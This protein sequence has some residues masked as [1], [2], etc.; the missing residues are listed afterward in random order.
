MPG[1]KTVDSAGDADG[2][3]VRLLWR[4]HIAETEMGAGE[5]AHEPKDDGGDSDSAGGSGGGSDPSSSLHQGVIWLENGKLLSWGDDGRV[6]L[7]L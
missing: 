7:Y 6:V 2:D 1:R 5:R 3:D 4:W